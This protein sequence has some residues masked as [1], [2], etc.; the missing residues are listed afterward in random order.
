MLRARS[1]VPAPR[2]GSATR[3]RPLPRGALRGRW[4]GIDLPLLALEA[5]GRESDTPGALA[6]IEDSGHVIACNARAAACGI[7]AG[8]SG[9][10]AYALATDLE[11]L[12]RNETLE[13]DA[14]EALAA[15]AGQFTSLVSLVVPRMVL[16][17]VGASERL[18]G[19]IERLLSIVRDGVRRLDYRARFAVAPTALGACLLSRAGLQPVVDRDALAGTLAKVPVECLALDED[20]TTALRAM[21]LRT[22]G[23]C[24]RLPRDGLARRVGPRV[25]E[26]LDRALGKIPDPR[27][28]YVA[29][30][31]FERRLPLPAPACTVD[32][33]LFP[34]HRLVHELTGFLAARDA[35]VRG[36]DLTLF[37]RGSPPSRITITLLMPGRD[38]RHL[39]DVLAERLGRLRLPEAVQEVALASRDICAAVPRNLDF[40]PGADAS[41]ASWTC[42]LERLRAHLGDDSVRMLETVADHRP[43]RAWRSRMAGGRRAGRRVEHAVPGGGPR[44][45]WLL[46]EPEP[47]RAPAD[48]PV[49]DG[50]LRLVSS[51]ERIESGWWDGADVARD[52]FIACNTAGEHFWVFRERRA[53]GRWYLH[54]VFA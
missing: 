11:V 19:G 1:N 8:M 10:A 53:P 38:P 12:E 13:A 37:H 4:L 35:A 5:L 16:L 30:P 15:W 41:R 54:G 40:F 18:F 44:P 22:F 48:T 7:V 24:C 45:L 33:V 36:L 3:A 25:V 43:E 17:E 26:L 9:R 2:T 31:C 39:L 49:L 42:L 20:V 21:G 50:V 23:D 34:L 52:Y 32:A 27:A 51:A 46:A 6:V 14:L 47:L 28:P 29:L